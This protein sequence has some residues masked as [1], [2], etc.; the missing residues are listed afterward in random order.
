MSPCSCVSVG[1]CTGTRSSESAATTSEVS[2]VRSSW[3]RVARNSS[4]SRSTRSCSASRAVAS[5]RSRCAA[6][7]RPRLR[8]AALAKQIDEHRHL[9]TQ[10]V[11]VERLDHEIDGAAGVRPAHLFR[12]DVERRQ[13][14]DRGRG[15]ALA[16]RIRR[17]TS[18]PS[19]I[20]ICASRITTA[21]S[22]VLQ[23]RQ[24]LGSRRGPNNADVGL[25]QHRFQRDE[26]RRRV[27]DRQY[28]DSPRSTWRTAASWL[29]RRRR[30]GSASREAT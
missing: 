13:E 21:N 15:P 9:R 11:R 23:Q 10:D 27:V 29:V 20:G 18:K 28:V 1:S 30:S 5:A 24:R 8:L 2:G 19:R 12:R 26:I 14:D 6:A 17:A 25:G 7:S 4:F 16:F 22:R 3:A